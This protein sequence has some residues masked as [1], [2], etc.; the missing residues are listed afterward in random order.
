MPGLSPSIHVGIYLPTSGRDELFVIALAALTAVLETFQE[1]YHGVPVYIRADANVNPSNMPRLQ[2]FNNFLMQFNLQSLP[3]HHP[4]HHHFMGNGDSDTQLDVLLYLGPPAQAESLLSIVCGKENPLISS[5]HDMVVSTFSCP[6]VPYI[7]PPPAIVAPRVPNTRVKV[8]WNQE[9][10]HQYETLLSSA[11]PLL[12]HSLHSPSSPSLTSIL[13]DCTNFALNRAAEASFKTLQLSKP[14]SQRK[15]LVNHD[16]KLAQTVALKAAQV[17]QNTRSSPTSSPHDI[18]SALTAKSSATSALRAAVRTTTRE[19]ARQRDELLHSVLSSDP[20]KL[21]TAVRKA[22]SLGVPAVHLL[23]VGKHTY[24]GDSVPDG[25]YESLLNLKVPDISPINTSEFLSTTENYRHIVELAK[26]GPPLP[27]L[28]VQE[29]AALLDRVRPDVLDLFSISARHYLMAGTAGHAHFAALLNLIIAN[30]NLSTAAELNS[31]WSIMLH[32]GHGKP[33]SLC[34]SWR[35]ISTCPLVPKALDLY[36][37]DLHRDNWVHASAPTQFMTRGSSH[38]LAALLLTEC[39]CFATV[40]LGISLY[41]LFLDKQSAFDSVLKEHILSEAFSAAGHHADQSL[42]YMANRLSTRRT[43]LQFS[44]TLMGP[45]HDQRGVEQGGVYSGDQF[46]LANNEELIATNMAGLGLNMGEV[47]V[48][49]IGVADDVALISPSPHALQSLLN[50]SQSLTSSRCMVNV[51]EKTKLLLYQPK[52]DQSAE[53]WLDVQPITM[54]GV[55]LPL[56]SQ[57]EHVGVLRSPGGSNLAS[58]TARMAGHTKSLYSVIS[59]GMARSHRGNPAASL[60]VEACYS[61]PKLF[62]GLASQTWK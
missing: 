38:E 12:Q 53:Y 8:L 30:I 14:P 9:G 7:P 46:Q 62:S 22:K 32:K 28:S 6:S 50:I 54:D 61:A 29:A 52:G 4:T 39:I 10:Q 34:R 23:Q 59:C 18:Q 56:S 25:F 43:Y 3:L 1:D 20:G 60:R 57:A 24:A 45:I 2:L 49:S 36:V 41:V 51:P 33:R 44:S 17:L 55:A 58:I 31:T 5:H 19:D 42:L 21:Q 13:L 11:L 47:S 35:C 16:V 48:G 27:P 37:A 15:Q 40:T 26:S